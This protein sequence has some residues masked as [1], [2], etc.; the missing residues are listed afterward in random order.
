M[1]ELLSAETWRQS[2][3]SLVDRVG[4]TA[5]WLLPAVAGAV[6]ILLVGWGV[7]RIVQAI[8]R[9]FLS[10]VGLDR[11]AG[12]LGL[13]DSLR[14]A[15]VVMA[16]SA[17]VARLLFWILML[18]FA[19]AAT[20]T[21]GLIA[22][23]TTIDRLIGFLPNVAGAALIVV[24]GF[25]VGRAAQKLVVSGASIAGL[26]QADKL[27]AAVHGV[28][29]VVAAVVAMEQLGL[30]T[31]FLVTVITVLVATLSLTLGLAFA[32]GSRSLITHILAG[33]Y[34]RQSLASGAVVEIGERK[35]VVESIGAVNTVLRK[36][37]GSW[38]L[39]NAT[40]LKGVEIR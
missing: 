25:V 17:I 28:L 20:E 24:L 23:T 37:N 7:S 27:G 18:T 1:G 35:G 36:E 39:P 33:H 8:T 12:R 32:L 11:T 22:V 30:R 10:R 21:L 31:D 15:N 9:R 16:P 14:R 4:E 29:L 3:A 5:G 2:L 26:P 13:T 34:L 19:L 38:L 40:V 6:L